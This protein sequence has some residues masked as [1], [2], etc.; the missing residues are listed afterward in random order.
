[1]PAAVTLKVVGAGTMKEKGMPCAC[2]ALSGGGRVVPPGALSRMDRD[3]SA[4]T[5]GRGC[6]GRGGRVRRGG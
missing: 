6:E 2:V 4:M 1:M 3:W 5:G